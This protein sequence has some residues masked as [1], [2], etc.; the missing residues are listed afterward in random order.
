MTTDHDTNYNKW[1]QLETCE[2]IAK[3]HCL[4]IRRCFISAYPVTRYIIV[5]EKASR[6]LLLRSCTRKLQLHTT[7]GTPN[8]Y[9]EHTTRGEARTKGHRDATMRRYKKAGVLKILDLRIM[10]TYINE[11]YLHKRAQCSR[12]HQNVLPEDGS[13]GP[14]H[15]VR[16]RIPIF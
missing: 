8:Q 16:N 13:V 4:L 10:T 6:A 7:L 9:K 11:Y 3:S 14:K 1:K 15:V 2:F 12:F 5:V